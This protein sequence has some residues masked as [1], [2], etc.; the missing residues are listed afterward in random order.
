MLPEQNPPPNSPERISIKHLFHV[1]LNA[2]NLDKGIGF[3]LKSLLLQPASAVHEYLFH[4]RRRLV[5]PLRFL[6]FTTAIA[7]FINIKFVY[8]DQTFQEGFFDVKAYGQSSEIDTTEAEQINVLTQ[9]ILGGYL[10]FVNNYQNLLLILF[11]P[12][13]ALTSWLFFRRKRLFLGEHLAINSYAVGF[14]NLLYILIAPL[15]VIDPAFT[16]LYFVITP[17]YLLYFY[18]AVFKAKSFRS[19][20]AALG[21]I[22]AAYSTY[23]LF[24]AF[25]VVILTI[26][27]VS[28]S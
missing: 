7:A 18:L 20:L 13:S 14:Q 6:F 9:K 19:V 4:N 27:Y 15:I 2:L 3:T 21:T 28:L 5:H 1:L 23:V 25:T 10:D 16:I 22:L 11:V 12:I 8:S 26:Y 17:L 24:L